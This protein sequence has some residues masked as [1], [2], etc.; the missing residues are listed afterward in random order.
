[1]D[2]GLK[3]KVAV[4]TGG[5]S[6]IGL[7]TVRLFLDEGARVAICGRDRERLAAVVTDLQAR[8]T[9]ERVLGVGC[10]VTN[11]GEVGAFSERVR[12]AFGGADILINNA[13]QGRVS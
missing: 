4:V 3:D 11:A 2:V 8:Y 6:G 1:M 12:N 13:G 5:S 10:D 9:T 7:A